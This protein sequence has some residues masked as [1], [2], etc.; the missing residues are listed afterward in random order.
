MYI[1][2]W[3]RKDMQHRSQRVIVLRLI[4]LYHS[5][6]TSF[7]NPVASSASSAI[8]SYVYVKGCAYVV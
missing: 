1:I 7:D 6:M 4:Y 8:Y 2:I 3:R 5:K